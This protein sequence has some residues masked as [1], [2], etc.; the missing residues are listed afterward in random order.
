MSIP[1]WSWEI[2]SKFKKVHGSSLWCNLYVHLMV[3]ETKFSKF[4]IKNHFSELRRRAYTYIK[5]L[6]TYYTTKM[7]MLCQSFI[8]VL[9]AHHNFWNVLQKFFGIQN[10]PIWVSCRFETCYRECV[11]CGWLPSKECFEACWKCHISCSLEPHH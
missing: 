8:M 1:P 5:N 11:S 9:V 7:V 4:I 3:Y 6:A 10:W 2:R